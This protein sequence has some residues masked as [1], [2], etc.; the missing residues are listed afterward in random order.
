M[1]LT[2]TEVQVDEVQ[3]RFSHGVC[4][5]ESFLFEKNTNWYTSTQ[6]MR[7]ASRKKTGTLLRLSGSHADSGHKKEAQLRLFYYT[8]TNFEQ[9]ACSVHFL[10]LQRCLRD[11]KQPPITFLFLF[12]FE[13]AISGGVEGV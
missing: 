5:T 3:L 4:G 13:A 2:E 11:S 8:S 6:K 9:G 1:A 10:S 12:L 7:I